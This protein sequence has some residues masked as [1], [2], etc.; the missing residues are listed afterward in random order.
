LTLV[1]RKVL[2]SAVYGI[3][4]AAS[5]LLARKTASGLWR[6]A[7]HEEPPTKR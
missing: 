4:G 7:T 5:T 6:V 1:L 2:W 3:F